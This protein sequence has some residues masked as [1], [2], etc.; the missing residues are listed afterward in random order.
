MV[1]NVSELL[2]SINLDYQPHV[3]L[4]F[5][6][7]YGYNRILKGGGGDSPNLP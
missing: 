1:I 7:S 6:V 3:L 4:I 5:L 2:R